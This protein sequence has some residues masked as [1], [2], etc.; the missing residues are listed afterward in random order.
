M[1]NSNP[2]KYTT[3]FHMRVDDTFLQDLDDLRAQE[4]PLLNRA[5]FV[6][7]LVADAKK[8]LPTAKKG[9]RK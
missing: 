2:L 1:P 6:R 5:D 8:N 7:K 4:R 9:G 3:G